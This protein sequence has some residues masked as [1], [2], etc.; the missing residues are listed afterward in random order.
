MKNSKLRILAILLALVMLLAACGGGG[1]QGNGG[2]NGGS[3]QAEGENNIDKPK[4]EEGRK[5]GELDIC[6]ASE[7]E[8]IDPALN[9]AVD[10]AVMLNH[11]FEGLVKW[12]DDGQ[13]N[14]VL[15][16]GQ[17]ES[18]EKSEDELTWTFK[19]RDGITWSDGQPVTA[20]DFEYAWKRLVDPTTGADY[21][22]MLESVEGYAEAIEEE[23]VE[24]LHAKALDDKTF[25]V[26]LIA[27]TP[28]FEEIAAFPATFPVRKDIVEDDETWTNEPDTYI[29][30]GPFKM[31][32][33]EHHK[34]IKMEKN[35][36][37]Y[38][39]DKIVA[40]KINF[41]LQ[42]N[43]TSIY[44]SYRAGE[45]DYIEQVPQEEVKPLIDSG[46]LQILPYVGTYFVCF[47]T[48][49]APFDDVRVRKA[50]S[51]V[52]D[53]NFIVDNVSASGEKVASGFVPMGV[54]DIDG[55]DGDDFRTKGGD[56]YP[57]DQADYEANVEKA[58]KLLEEAGYPNGEGFPVVEYLYN[59][60]DNHKAIGEAL[61]DMWQ[62]KLGVTVT[63]QN[64]DWNVFLT[65]RKNGNFSIARHGWIADYND[66]MTFLDMWVTGGGNNDAQWSNDEF[67]D[68]IKSAKSSSDQVERMDLMHQAEDIMMEDEAI[69]A[70]IYF[71]VNK[72]MHKPNIEGIYYT[73]L[74]Y[75]FFGYSTGY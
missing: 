7:P 36:E 12:V 73:P 22:Y 55:A 54:S 69:V 25:E 6:I 62:E 51:L 30:N 63:L 2:Q 66:P 13:G 20:H 15:A 47:N 74:G 4:F 1:E 14:A 31:S 10:G 18:W 68:L 65:E 59:T 19:L 24:K 34:V 29:G 5:D 3:E 26:K 17:A 60:N 41:H 45:L 72:R 35:P 38:E 43:A 16:P 53:R 57:I 50:F 40:D 58:Q 61:Q 52:I 28:F 71:Y 67:D 9:T 8:S 44:S 21:A 75:N 27:V 64:Q 56:Y 70:P 37:Y 11:L 23:D 39:A 46:E 49:E 42:D 33:W 48:K 32:A